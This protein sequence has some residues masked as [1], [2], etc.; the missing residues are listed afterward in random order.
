MVCLLSEAV[1]LSFL[2]RSMVHRW[3]CFPTEVWIHPCKA[4][5]DIRHKRSTFFN[6]CS[7]RRGP[8][9]SIRLKNSGTT[10]RNIRLGTIHIWQKYYVIFEGIISVC[11]HRRRTL[12][13]EECVTSH[14]WCRY[15]L[16]VLVSTGLEDEDLAS[17][18]G[19]G[20][21]DWSKQSS[22]VVSGLN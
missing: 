22:C 2:T 3:F 1:T 7:Q 16:V 21:E 17:S 18:R 15:F 12:S 5:H 19:C 4:I 20:G 13:L 14:I 9:A 6:S 11:V 10:Q 8:G